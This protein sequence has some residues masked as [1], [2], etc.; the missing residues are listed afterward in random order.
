MTLHLS[1]VKFPSRFES[2]GS[3]IDTYILLFSN[4]HRTFPQ[5]FHRRGHYN[6]Y[7]ANSSMCFL[8][9]FRKNNEIQP[10]KKYKNYIF[11]AIFES[12]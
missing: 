6:H 5:C 2:I 9:D 8:S 7:Q 10:K 4:L 3:V 1:F 12:E 11:E